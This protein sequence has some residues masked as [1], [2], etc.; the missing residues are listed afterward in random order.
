MFCV[1]GV[2]KLM[3]HVSNILSMVALKGVV[4]PSIFVVMPDVGNYGRMEGEV[5]IGEDKVLS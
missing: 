1:G 4:F 5:L 3:I 2:K